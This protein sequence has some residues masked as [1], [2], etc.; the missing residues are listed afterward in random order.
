[1]LGRL[2]KNKGVEVLLE[3]KELID[4]INNTDTFAEYGTAVK[5]GGEKTYIIRFSDIAKTGKTSKSQRIQ[6]FKELIDILKNKEEYSDISVGIKSGGSSAGTM[7]YTHNG[8]Q[9]KVELKGSGGTGV[10]GDTDIKEGLVVFLYYSNINSP[11]DKENYISR[12]ESLLEKIEGGIEGVDEST[13]NKI[14]SWLEGFLEDEKPAK[15]IKV[16]NQTL[17]SSLTIKEGY[18]NQ[19]LIRDDLFDTLRRAA[20]NITK[21]PSDKWNPGD[22]YVQ[23]SEVSDDIISLALTEENIEVINDLFNDEWGGKDKPLTSISL[24]QE[25]A[26]GG[27]AKSLLGTYSKVKNDYN[28]TKDEQGYNNDE[29]LKAISDSRERVQSLIDR[30]EN[31]EYRLSNKDLSRNIDDIS[32]LRGKF[33]ALKSLEF[34]FKQFADDE[35]DNALVALVGFAISLT[36]INPTFFKVTG[37]SS[38]NP[39]K[40]DSFKRG[41]NVSLYNEEGNF[42]PIIIT[43]SP[44]FGGI[45]IDFKIEKGGSP[46]RA[47]INARNNGNI[48][49][50]LEVQKL[51]HLA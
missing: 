36:G 4:L 23:I 51:V 43:D 17:S 10:G 18:P 47:R 14:Q 27:K 28:L 20:T 11:F 39:T 38:G 13:T 29:Y 26:Q 5:D 8:I 6:I 50:T 40:P 32:F 48:Q 16:I 45:E 24:K 44:T 46:Y 42:D 22:I 3:N 21:F 25:T 49:G 7:T 12:V 30:N 15:Y 1:M 37:S 34:L 19:K 35:V 9:Y 31:I 2:L 41:D 33:A